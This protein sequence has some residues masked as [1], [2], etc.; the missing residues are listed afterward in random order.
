[1]ATINKRVDQDGRMRFQVIVRLKGHPTQTATF[2]RIT[3]AKKWAQQTEA[4]IREG[5]YFKTAEAKK[6]SLADMIDRYIELFDPPSYKKAQL[7]WWK[8]FLGRYLLCDITPAMIASGRDELLKGITKRGRQRSPS[9]AVRYIAAISHVFTIGIKEFG[10]LEASPVS[11]ITKPREP[12]GRVRFL[13]DEE[14][15]RLLSACK[16]SYSPFLYIVVVLA[17]SSGMRLSEIMNLTWQQVDLQRR[18]I[19]LQKTKNKTHRVI[20]LAN[21]ALELLQQHLQERQLHSN[22][23]FP[24]KIIGKPID[25]RKAWISALKQARIEDFRF[26]DLRHSAASYMAMSGSSLVDIG[27]L[28]G[29]KRLEVTKRYSH[30]SERHISEVVERMNERIFG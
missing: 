2:S 26:H 10:W 11:K 30:L 9:T 28:L 1:M 19:I 13:S 8:Q 7:E 17:L 15:E 29:H 22:L 18:Q 21:L 6:H 16:H 3:D 12:A 5:R 23:L 25:I 27:I 20:P 24:G 4:A 14:R